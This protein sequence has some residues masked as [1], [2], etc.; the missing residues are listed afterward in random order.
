MTATSG[1]TTNQLTSSNYENNHRY[2]IY[3]E[4]SI[5]RHKNNEYKV[6]DKPKAPVN[7]LLNGAPIQPRL[8]TASV[9]CRF[10]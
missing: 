10:S 4:H 6:I 7:L 2:Y 1:W 5:D 8:K 9:M 3:R